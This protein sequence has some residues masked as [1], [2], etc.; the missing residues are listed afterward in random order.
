M[1]ILSLSFLLSLINVFLSI[2][3]SK[4]DFC[5]FNK[6]IAFGMRIEYEIFSSLVVLILLIVI[7]VLLKGNFRYIFLSLFLLGLSNLLVRILFGGVCDYISL[8]GISF[9]LADFFILLISFYL[10]FRILLPELKRVSTS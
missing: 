6:G 4:I 2:Y 1:L 9:N 7:G 10:G 8:L 5:I 3:L